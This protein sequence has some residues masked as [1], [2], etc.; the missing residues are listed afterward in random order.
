MEEI[1]QCGYQIDKCPGALQLNANRTRSS[2]H[3]LGWAN[4]AA[5]RCAPKHTTKDKACATCGMPYTNA[6]S[7]LY[8][9]IYL[10]IRQHKVDEP[11]GLTIYLQNVDQ[12]TKT[13]NRWR[14][15][16]KL[17]SWRVWTTTRRGL[18][19]CVRIWSLRIYGALWIM[20]QTIQK[21]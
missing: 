18:W 6:Y 20:G 8:I 17:R 9:C 4:R 13:Q 15:N 5:L 14:Y 1:E 10:K 12:Q 21:R 2:G 11:K 3:C 7:Y 16:C 19:R